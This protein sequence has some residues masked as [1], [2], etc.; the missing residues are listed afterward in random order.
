MWVTALVTSYYAS[1]LALTIRYLVGSM[2]VILPWSHCEEEWRHMGCIDSSPTN[3]SRLLRLN[4][5]S[6][7][8][9]QTS[10]EMYF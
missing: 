9:L 6:D 8:R 5:T 2:S 4:A 7:T 10:A 3:A 1:L